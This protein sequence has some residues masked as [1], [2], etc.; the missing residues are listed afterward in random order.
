M[1]SLMPAFQMLVGSL[2][3]CIKYFRLFMKILSRLMNSFVPFTYSRPYCFTNCRKVYVCK[4]ASESVDKLC[5]ALFMVM[6]RD[7]TNEI[8]AEKRTAHF[9]RDPE[10]P[11]IIPGEIIV[12][13]FSGIR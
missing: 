3:F 6:W 1:K 10:K 8:Q 12:Y 11:N 9:I 7:V 5:W 13:I 4:F 2:F